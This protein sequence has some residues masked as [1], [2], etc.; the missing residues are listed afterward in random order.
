MNFLPKIAKL[1]KQN[2]F[3]CL[4]IFQNTV[5]FPQTKGLQFS[6]TWSTWTSNDNPPIDPQQT[7]KNQTSYNDNATWSIETHMHIERLFKVQW[8]SSYNSRTDLQLS[9]WW[10]QIQMKN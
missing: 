6:Q 4:D 3:F 8:H 7:Q 5:S 2:N 10:R 1:F 9:S